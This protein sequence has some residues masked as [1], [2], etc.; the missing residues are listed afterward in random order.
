M[1]ISQYNPELFESAFQVPSRNTTSAD[2]D[3]HKYFFLD[4]ALQVVRL[5]PDSFRKELIDLIYDG[6][7][8]LILA[9][10]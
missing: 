7:A 1:I 4:R 9:I 3:P 5:A 8:V 2:A 10:V 6:L